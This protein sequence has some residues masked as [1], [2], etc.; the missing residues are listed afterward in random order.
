MSALLR[1]L[2]GGFLA[3]VAGPARRRPDAD[4]EADQATPATPPTT[5]APPAAADAKETAPPPGKGG[6]STPRDDPFPSTYK[7][8]AAPPFAIR[9]A[10]L[11]TAAGPVIPNGTILVRDGKIVAVGATVDVPADADRH[12]R[13]RQVRHAGH[14]R[15]PL[16][17]R[18]LRGA[19]HPRGRGRQ[20]DD[21]AEHRGGVGRALGVAAGSAVP[22]QS[23]RRR[24]DHPGAAG[25]G[26][27][28]R[29]P[30]HR[31]EGGARAAPSRT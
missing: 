14:H 7:A 10:T 9:N 13:R 21:E 4:P 11:L 30:Q 6:L 23:R 5:P 1:A 3:V 15:R 17:P 20:R 28:V 8:P 25:V 2:A 24:H 27:P 22:A 18:R 31:A 12:R 16:A 19:R 29:R 26:Q